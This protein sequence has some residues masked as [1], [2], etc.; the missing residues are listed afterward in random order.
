MDTGTLCYLAG[1]KD[2]EHAASG[3]MGGPIMEAAVLSEIIKTFTHRGIDP[4]IYFWRTSAGSEVDIL[5]QTTS[6]MVPIEVKLSAT[7]QSAMAA[8]IK[9]FQKVLSK[10][11]RR[12][13]GA[14][15]RPP[16]WQHQITARAECHSP[17]LHRI[18]T[19]PANT[20]PHGA[21]LFSFNSITYA[22][23]ASKAV[24]NNQ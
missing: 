17:T 20:Q 21:C 22:R 6:G 7:P 16:S 3:P 19:T 5:V 12:E 18:V 13:C 9:S 15:L 10:K 14:G 4:Q 1:L 2:P 24:N 11:H 8:T 23:P